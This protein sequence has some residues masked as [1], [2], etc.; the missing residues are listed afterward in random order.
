M[1]NY[2]DRYDSESDAKPA[3]SRY[4]NYF[5]RYD[6][7]SPEP[8]PAPEPVAAPAPEEPGFIEANVTG[9]LRTGYNRA[10]RSAN[11]IAGMS[12]VE[13]V[14]E[15]AADAAARN[16][17]IEAVPRS[18]FLEAARKEARTSGTLLGTLGAYVKNPVAAMA[19]ALES[20][21]ESGVGMGLAAGTGALGGTVAGSIGGPP[22]V[23]AG[24]T[25]GAMAGIGFGSY[26]TEYGNVVAEVLQN[27]NVDLSDPAALEAAMLNPDLMSAA[28][29][30]AHARGVPIAVMDALSM[31]IA[32]R[33][34]K[35]VREAIKPV[36][37]KVAG[38]VA[39]G[40]AEL[41]AQSV[42]GGAGEAGAQLADEGRISDPVAIGE[43]M[44]GELAPGAVEAAG[45]AAL[46]KRGEKAA[47][48][49]PPG[50]RGPDLLDE[51]ENENIQSEIE[52]TQQA[53][54][55]QAAA[56]GGDALDQE[57]AAATE[58]VNRTG[59]ARGAKIGAMV[60]ALTTAKE[61]AAAVQKQIEI[62]Q[63]YT[64]R[65]EAK[66][67]PAVA[68]A[69]L[70]SAANQPEVGG[71]SGPATLADVWPAAVPRGTPQVTPQVAP[72]VTPQAAA[73]KTVMERR[74]IA[75]EQPLALPAPKTGP[76]ITAPEF[77][78]GKKG[79]RLKGTAPVTKEGGG[80]VVVNQRGEAQVLSENTPTVPGVKT[81]YGTLAIRRQAI[82]EERVRT[83]VV[84]T[85][86]A[87]VDKAAAEPA[88]P[89]PASASS[90]IGFTTAKGSTYI[91]EADGRTTRD[92]APRPEHPGAKERGPQPTSD[93]TFYVA[94][95][96]AIK[97]AEIQAQGGPAT[98]VAAMGDG[99]YGVQYVEGRDKGKFERRTVV[100]GESAPA[101]G[102]TP[103]ELW[104]DGRRVHFGNA[105]TAVR[106]AQPAA[107]LAAAPRTL[108]E[109]R[110]QDKTVR[111]EKAE[112]QERPIA[113]PKPG[114][115][116]VQAP[117]PV[118]EAAPA[119]AAVKTLA[120]RRA[121]EA[122]REA[123][124]AARAAKREVREKTEPKNEPPKDR[125]RFSEGPNVLD[126]SARLAARQKME[127][128]QEEAEDNALIIELRSD[129]I[130]RRTK[131]LGPLATFYE[132]LRQKL[133]DRANDGRH[134]ARVE[135]RL[136]NF[137]AA[138]DAMQAD[139][140]DW[141]KVDAF[142]AAL[143]NL[144]YELREAA[145]DHE[146]RLKMMGAW[147]PLGVDLSQRPKYEEEQPGYKGEPTF[148]PGEKAY[149]RATID[150][151]LAEYESGRAA[152]LARVRPY[153]EER[154]ATAKQAL[155]D[156][157]AL[158]DAEQ[159][160]RKRQ[161]LAR[162]VKQA[163]Q[164][165]R[166]LS[167]PMLR[168]SEPAAKGTPNGGVPINRAESLTR[169]MKEALGD[170]FHMLA[171]PS[172]A[173]SDV[174][175]EME[176]RGNL[177][178]P[179]VFDTQTGKVYMFAEN[180]PSEEFLERKVAHEVV[181]HLGVRK[182]LG[183]EKHAQVVEDVFQTAENR[184][185]I[186][187][188]LTR[189]GLD[190]N[191]ASARAT[192][193]DEY[194]AMIAESQTE[195]GLLN[196][197]IAMVRAALRKLGAKVKWTDNDIRNLLIQSQ[198]N[199]DKIS[200]HAWHHPNQTPRL[201]F[202]TQPTPPSANDTGPEGIRIRQDMTLESLLQDNRTILRQ[203]WDYL[204]Q[205]AHKGKDSGL[206]FIHLSNLPDFVQPGKMDSAGKYYLTATDQNG[207]FNQFLAKYAPMT[208]ELGAWYRKNIAV[209]DEL[210]NIIHASTIAGPDPSLPYRPRYSG[211]SNGKP[212]KLSAEQEMKNRQWQKQ[213]Q[214]LRTAWDRLDRHGAVG[215]QAKQFYTQIRDAYVDLNTQVWKALEARINSTS[216]G[217]SQ[218]SKLLDA[219]RK[220]FESVKVP[221]VYFALFR[222]GDYW[223]VA[224]NKETGENEFAV[225]SDDREKMKLWIKQMNAEGFRA[226]G[227]ES[228]AIT[229]DTMKDIDPNFVAKIVDLTQEFDEPEIADEVWQLYLKHL[230]EMSMRKH[231]IHRLNRLG[232]TKDYVQAF[233]HT[234]FH[235]A[236]Q[237]ARLRY[238]HQLNEHLRN[239]E[240]ELRVLQEN[241][242]AEEG[243]ATPVLRTLK[244][245]HK[246]VN[247]PTTAGWA[248]WM[249]TGAF[250]HQ[251]SVEPAPGIVNLS[252]FPVVT[253]GEF[254]AEHGVNRGTRE[255]FRAA[256]DVLV[257]GRAS[258]KLQ[259]W[260]QEVM[261]DGDRRGLFTSTNLSTM[262]S[263]GERGVMAGTKAETAIRIAGYPFQAPEVFNREAT[264]L[265][266]LRLWRMKHPNTTAQNTADAA[267]RNAKDEDQKDALWPATSMAKAARY[268]QA[269]ITSTQGDYSNF[270]RPG[271]MQGNW[272]KVMFIFRGYGLLMAYRMV[273][274]F[275]RSVGLTKQFDN[276]TAAEFKQRKHEARVRFGATL[277]QVGLWAGMRGMPLYWLMQ[278]VANAFL[279]DDDDPM[280]I[281]SQMAARLEEFFTERYGP[282]KG[283]L[284]AQA[285]MEGSVSTLTRSALSARMG[286]NNMFLQEPP[287]NKY[288]AELLAW[289][290]LQL[291]GF[292]G[293]MFANIADAINPKVEGYEDRAIER[294]I[295]K[296][297]RDP[298]KAVRYA[299]EGVTT[300]QGDVVVPRSGLSNYE[301]G[302]QAIGLQPL[303]VKWQYEKNRS[304][305]AEAE[306]IDRREGG[307]R[308]RWLI[309]RE[310]GDE[311]A[312]AEAWAEAEKFDAKHP[313][314]PIIPG[315]RDSLKQRARRSAES[316]NG[317]YV[318]RRLRQ[319]LM[320][321]HGSRPPPE[322]EPEGLIE[323][324]NIDLHKRPVIKNSDGS[325]ST[326]R[327]LSF[328]NEKGEVLVPT[329]SDDGRVLS[330]RDAI[331][332][333][334]R[335]GKHLGIFKTP[336]DATA[337]AKKLH[338]EQAQE[339]ASE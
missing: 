204:R 125:L 332:Q 66:A 292:Y 194:L 128:E 216:A 118:V 91:V 63:A 123:K 140:T 228:T 150:D 162:A 315:L 281:D 186:Q 49:T 110:Q 181:A 231:H 234:M 12:G 145:R 176:R 84:E 288:G 185:W 251:L 180:N 41:S 318:D 14:G 306:K 241:N 152:D 296:W 142:S 83:P 324:G 331:R 138:Y 179:G 214:I 308:N 293:S 297:M 238:G 52:Q 310:V 130:R 218:K 232:F 72:Q 71:E 305:L 237:L 102:L 301:I 164:N 316:V 174:Y 120:E 126:L 275:K 2:F 99:R 85:T 247:N 81:G 242:D 62:D 239:A 111:A 309:A 258:A 77:R 285:I 8:E 195:I 154:I 283:K 65:D 24:A 107:K 175:A 93:H 26:A 235:G 286:M 112:P 276:E 245:R 302:L 35:P 80:A 53:A 76:T 336:K 5:D 321:K 196:R 1:A 190:E 28:R 322:E 269:K 148:S 266:A 229:K 64:Q 109:R 249:A 33:I 160:P 121:K 304:I 335:T 326:V 119:E 182:L 156:Y 43:E 330:D 30:K 339:Y 23:A 50:G 314:R 277:G 78:T 259:G 173:P 158:P 278:L 44:V 279:G 169:K 55:E 75:A 104:K 267:W 307:I 273:R 137:E 45:G 163:E 47:G 188:F 262:V 97:L 183:L 42:A 313:E 192:A 132:K 263:I 208:R 319:S 51:L 189:H 253:W 82:Q 320:E 122:R 143:S 131:T 146:L 236:H 70:Q 94:S 170:S 193:G 206:A 198:S 31:G 67:A 20:L 61:Q 298:W 73:P 256:K 144:D 166:D 32:G 165:L 220:E 68:Q 171:R 240:K 177:K 134:D 129:D 92:K 98:R 287:E 226:F 34:L 139:P 100:K 260:E 215:K 54:R 37:G 17:A 295:P 18:H 270:N 244:R 159:N 207:F 219:L 261:E 39:G 96:D 133:P 106:T 184:E 328:G 303:D 268:G 250:L 90:V 291:V 203:G 115:V 225:R 38:T 289:Y 168:F 60:D 29:K 282:E 334:Q 327:S 213:Y 69:E 114:K 211:M 311:E 108:T 10:L 299:K 15:A 127:V 200:G 105:I 233:S 227:G 323:P 56:Q 333:Y 337:Y 317:V 172:Q 290:G 11:I 7:E 338:E 147:P 217:E 230:P 101:V 9:P 265:A 59:D 103:V 210:G 157:I 329:V 40:T 201:F 88:S 117:T 79:Q 212:V 36:L 300:K 89:A 86:R 243:I 197:V 153:Y 22:L 87:E 113:K 255:T 116:S 27:A 202:A 136:A 254:I 151:T 284:Y 135:K 21:A 74:A 209:A 141:H 199:L 246:W 264:Y 25:G 6:E 272:P 271:A 223:A 325:I 274:D 13:N 124:K 191:D 95:E 149:R 3:P 294:V 58:T 222:K 4:A 224:K 205:T 187:E 48:G 155:A 252:Q 312:M 57:L 280:D 221:G 178:A 19:L 16:R 248:N 46:A 257:I 167:N 161:R